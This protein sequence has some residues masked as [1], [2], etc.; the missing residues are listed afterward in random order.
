[1]DWFPSYRIFKTTSFWLFVVALTAHKI[2]V[3]RSIW[4]KLFL[5]VNPLAISPQGTIPNSIQEI[6]RTKSS[7]KSKSR[8]QKLRDSKIKRTRTM[9]EDTQR[10]W[11]LTA[12]VKHNR[13]C[14]SFLSLSADLIFLF[15]KSQKLT[16][17]ENQVTEKQR[18]CLKPF[19]ISQS[20]K[21]TAS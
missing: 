3:F 9:G 20:P 21:V 14:L 19:L 7:R 4:I 6:E 2:F 5:A 18:K 8:P 16:A 11:K 10:L 1:M 12:S 13:F 17:T 15:K